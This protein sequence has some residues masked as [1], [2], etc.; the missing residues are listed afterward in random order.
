MGKEEGASFE[1]KNKKKEDE[2]KRNIFSEVDIMEKD[3]EKI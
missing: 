1:M 2:G 3:E